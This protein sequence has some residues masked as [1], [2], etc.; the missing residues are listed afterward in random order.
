MNAEQILDLL[1]LRWK[2]L[3]PRAHRRLL[4]QLLR[5]ERTQLI[6]AIQDVL[7]EEKDRR[8]RSPRT[9]LSM[10]DYTGNWARS[11]E[12][13]GWNVVQVDIKHGED[14]GKWSARS[15]L[16]DIL[17]A[18]PT[19]DGVLAAPPCTAFAVSGARW[20]AAK[21]ADGRTAAAVHL[22]RQ[23]LRTI[24]LL[25]P[26]FW[27]LE[28]PIGRIA[29]LVPELGAPALSFDPCDFAGWTTSPTDRAEL[30]EIRR[31][32]RCSRS[33]QVLV[34]QTGAYTKRTLLWGRFQTP[35]RNRVEPVRCTT[36]GSWLQGLG[37]SGGEDTKT[38]R[39]VTPEGFALAFAAAQAGL[40]RRELVD[41]A[42]EML[43]DRL[44]AFVA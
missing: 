25:Q 16:Q 15:V 33:E 38:E 30:A 4:R 42:D 40:P 5:A 3:V 2:T 39:S 7:D 20:W 37:G 14:I 26:D 19:I 41:L 34:Q 24:D 9:V 12:L 32:G 28:N 22:V 31:R 44:D 17:Q 8:V 13:L 43:R 36:Q 11:F 21:D 1:A 29:T 23:A 27:A 6:D 35:R 10:F 18:F